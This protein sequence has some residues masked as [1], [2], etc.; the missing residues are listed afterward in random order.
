MESVIFVAHGTADDRE[1]ERTA[2]TIAENI[3]KRNAF[4][5]AEA[6]FLHG[7][8]S[9]EETVDRVGGRVVVVPLFFAPGHLAGTVL[10]QEVERSDLSPSSVR[11]TKPV[12]THP[13]IAEIVLRRAR[14]V[15]EDDTDH[16][17]RSSFEGVGLALLA[18]GSQRSD[19]HRTTV[20]QHAERIET[21]ADFDVVRDFYLE[22][23]PGIESV[24]AAFD[25]D[26]VIGV[27][28]F[29]DEGCHVLRD[30]PERVERGG[31]SAQKNDREDG[32][33]FRYADPIGTH[34]LMTEIAFDRARVS[35]A[36]GPRFRGQIDH[37]PGELETVPEDTRG[38][39]S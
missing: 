4:A 19:A 12:G 13:S 2:T 31:R 25:T 35:Q 28:L 27:P 26:D 30:V 3:G 10:P 32:L 23:E 16:S 8:P 14:D 21:T 29:L 6:A 22:E 15:R 5:T 9:F 37:V 11:I 7:S 1:S 34:P 33:P 36:A 24:G 39:S 18:H 20:R 17:R 38:R